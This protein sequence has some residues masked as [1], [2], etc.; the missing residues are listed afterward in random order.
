MR[1]LEEKG[2]D[3]HSSQSNSS[4]VS[5]SGFS[6]LLDMPVN[7]FTTEKLNGLQSKSAEKQQELSTL[8]STTPEM[9][10]IKEL[11]EL[12]EAVLRYYEER[13][14]EDAK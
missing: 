10:W 2:F 4:S 7:S 11:Q 1:L 5:G 3:K 6:Y 12:K 13:E 9:I 14:S 8:I